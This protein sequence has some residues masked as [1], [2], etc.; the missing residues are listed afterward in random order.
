MKKRCKE[1]GGKYET[2]NKEIT[3]RI[4]H[5]D[6]EALEDML[7]VQLTDEQRRKAMERVNKI[8][9]QV[10]RGEE[11]WATKKERRKMERDRRMLASCK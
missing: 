2:C 3:L 10:C 6:I 7:F 1:C 4:N 9:V 8:W 11:K 5:K